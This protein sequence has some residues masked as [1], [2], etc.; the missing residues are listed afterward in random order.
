MKKII[1]AFV[2]LSVGTGWACKSHGK[3]KEAVVKSPAEAKVE[4]KVEAKDSPW[5]MPEKS[6][7]DPNKKYSATIK[8]SK[9]DIKVELFAKEA[10]ISVTNFMQL[11]SKA[12]Y[13]GLTFHRVVPGFV[14]QGGDPT[15]TGKGGPG[16][17]LPAEINR[18]HIKGALAWARLPDQVNSEKRSSGSQFYITLE[19]QPFLDQGGYTV[20]GQV[21]EGTEI[22]DKI[23]VGDTIQDISVT[24]E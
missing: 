16:Y 8:T 4:S 13:R 9:G 24:S 17:T 18:K 6:E 21:T 11:S 12:F 22:V 14:I 23:Q 7:V 5:K 20:F 10:P 1:V 3:T 19:A 15:G 2:I